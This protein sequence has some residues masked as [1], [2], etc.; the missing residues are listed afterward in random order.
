[1]PSD[2]KSAIGEDKFGQ[3]VMLI[4]VPAKTLFCAYP[5]Y[6]PNAF[7]FFVCQIFHVKQ[8]PIE[9]IYIHCMH[10]N[11]ECI[12]NALYLQESLSWL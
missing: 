2:L 6:W 10:A 9:D 3:F 8:K 7:L 5:F 11:R 1:M 4:R 12:S